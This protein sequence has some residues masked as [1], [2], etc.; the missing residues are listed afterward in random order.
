[1]H[2][3]PRAKR[4]NDSPAGHAAVHDD[5]CMP[6]LAM[7]TDRRVAAVACAAAGVL[8]LAYWLI[9]DVTYDESSQQDQWLFVLFFSSVIFVFAPGTLAVA[10]QV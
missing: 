4:R 5:R 9:A 2:V 6:G 7:L 1:M 10:G 8:P 3:L